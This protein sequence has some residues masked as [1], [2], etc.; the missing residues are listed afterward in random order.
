MYTRLDRRLSRTMDCLWLPRHLMVLRLKVG[1][2]HTFVVNGIIVYYIIIHIA[3]ESSTVQ[4]QSEDDISVAAADIYSDNDSISSMKS[5]PLAQDVFSSSESNDDNI[6]TA[7]ADVYASDSDAIRPAAN[8]LVLESP[9]SSDVNPYEVVSSSPSDDDS[10][11]PGAI[12]GSDSD[13]GVSESDTDNVVPADIYSL[14]SNSPNAAVVGPFPSIFHGRESL[15]NIFSSSSD[16][17]EHPAANVYSSSHSNSDDALAADLQP[18]PPDDAGRI[19]PMTHGPFNAQFFSN[20]P[21]IWMNP[22][23]GEDDF[24]TDDDEDNSGLDDDTN[25]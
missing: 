6:S 21:G 25:I 9:I 20:V 24:A 14:S 2:F 23:V 11:V 4:V 3:R 22:P 1:V 13:P 18:P 10:P 15:E 19:I 16:G 7:A 17:D 12:F 5:Q 8:N